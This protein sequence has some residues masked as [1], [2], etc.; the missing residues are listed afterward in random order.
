[1]EIESL[2]EEEGLEEFEKP[3]KI[4]LIDADTIAYAA[5]STCQY[6]D[7]LLPREMYTDAEWKNICCDAQYDEKEQCIWKMDM[8]KAL[9]FSKNRIEEIVEKTFTKD[10][11]LYFSHGKNFRFTVHPMYKANRGETRYPPELYELKKL[12]LEEYNNQGCICTDVEA[13]D[14]VVYLKRKYPDRYVL[15]AVDKDVY[16]SVPGKHFN[17]YTSQKYNIPMK[18]VETTKEDA[19]LFP[20][21]QCLTGDPTDNIKGVPGVGPK[22]ALK[23]L[24][25]KVT[26]YERW[27]AVVSAFEAKGLTA[28]DAIRDMRLVNMHQVHR[29]EKGEYVWTPWTQPL[30]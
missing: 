12:I 5:A 4:A 27:K 2:G 25:D 14:V 30:I 10:V 18:W 26:P 8:E 6:A 19:E 7:D 28:I 24:K 17:Y 23:I 1:M 11:E 3:T 15:C 16:R 9:E 29:N 20:Y 22:T 13:D 21:I